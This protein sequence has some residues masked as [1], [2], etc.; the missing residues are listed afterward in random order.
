MLK[1]IG[2]I[3]FANLYPI[4]YC[5]EN[6]CEAVNEHYEFTDGVPSEINALLRRGLI[7]AGPSSSIE[8]LRN[9]HLYNLIDGHSVSSFGRIMSIILFSRAEIEALDGKTVLSSYQ[10][11]TSTGLLQIVL[12]KFYNLNVEIKTSRAPLME[13][14]MEHPAYLLIGDNALIEAASQQNN[15]FQRY[16]LGTIWYEQT[17]VPFVFALWISRKRCEG[18]EVAEL[19][20]KLD[21]AKAQ[22]VESFENIAVKSPY[23]RQFSTETLVSYWRTISYDLTGKHMAGLELF[24]KYLRELGLL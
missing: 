23:T 14:I 13:G 19:Q 9:P 12:R 7:D 2:R 16:D 8:Y 22:A 6:P 10:A 17:G 15:A 21:A 5:L 3:N 4:F 11:E 24:G 20:T 18:G 1:K